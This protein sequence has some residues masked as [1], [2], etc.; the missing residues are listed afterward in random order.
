MEGGLRV[1]DERDQV[2]GI[3]HRWISYTIIRG[4]LDRELVSRGIGFPVSSY[5]RSDK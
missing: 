5:Y 3:T 4:P 1:C 2:M